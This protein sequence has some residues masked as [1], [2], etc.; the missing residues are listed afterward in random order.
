[1]SCAFVKKRGDSVLRLV[2]NGDLRLINGGPKPSSCRRW[3]FTINGLECSEPKTIDT[4]IH[5]RTSI[6]NVHRTAYVEGYCRDIPA[7]HLNVAWNIG[8]CISQGHNVGDS[9]TGWSA[10]VRIIVEEVDVEDADTV[11]V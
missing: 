8:D 5:V 4:V 3:F 1:Q 9:Y 2:W 11:I 10:T 6:T 7:G